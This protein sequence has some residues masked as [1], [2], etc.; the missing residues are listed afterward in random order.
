MWNRQALLQIMTRWLTGLAL[1][2]LALLP[3]QMKSVTAVG[4]AR[5]DVAQG[6]SALCKINGVLVEPKV[7]NVRTYGWA[8][9]AN[10]DHAAS[11]SVTTCF[12][13]RWYG[14]AIRYTVAQHCTPVRSDRNLP[15]MQFGGVAAFDG[16]TYLSCSLPLWQSSFPDV[17]FTRVRMV[18]TQG[19]WPSSK[20][21]TFLT[22][23][24]ATFVARTNASCQLTIAST[25]N[26]IGPVAT[27]TYEHSAPATCG[28]YIELGSRIVPAGP[29]SSEGLHKIGSTIYGPVS[30]SGQMFMPT[31]YS[32]TI[33]AISET[34]TLDWF[35]IDPTPQRSG[36]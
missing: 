30:S 27:L 31:V 14:E 12:A 21:Y 6:N 5:P 22:S 26:L 17:F 24:Q 11:T 25:Y 34:Y 20:P 36:G 18:P 4:L 23:Q 35:L 16:N 9:V 32:F 1:S 13:E 10:F 2:A 19:N 7:D 15:R 29:T 28:S 33:G 8:F 3:S